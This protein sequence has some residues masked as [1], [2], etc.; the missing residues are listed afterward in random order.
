MSGAGSLALTDLTRRFG[1][2]SAPAAVDHVTVSVAEGELLAL[3]GASGS[4]KTTTLR[5]A[6]GYEPADEGRVEL[7][8]LDITR[9][10]PPEYTWDNFRRLATDTS[11]LPPIRN[12]VLMTLLATAAD[13]VVCA[14]AA[15]LLVFRRFHGRRLLGVL[16][17]LPWAIPPTAIAIGL[18][19]TFNR[20]DISAARVLLVGTFWILPLAYFIRG[21]PLVASAIEGSLRQLDPSLE[22]AALGLGAGWWQTLRHVIYPAARPGLVAGATLAAITAVGEFVA[23]EVLYTHANRPI[24][25]EILAQVRAFAFGTAAAYSVVLIGIVLL[26]TLLARA[27]EDGRRGVMALRS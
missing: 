10:L 22:E 11:L 14:L 16:V 20:T 21:V 1:G 15:Y 7:D 27:T 26:I 9:L 6:A 25:V 5:I 3:V 4:G 19:S 8:G 13:V 24:S 2:P 23:S 12:S 17:A 18:A